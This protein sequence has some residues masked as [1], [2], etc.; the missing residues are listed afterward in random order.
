LTNGGL[1]GPLPPELAGQ[2]QLNLDF[3]R[4]LCVLAGNH[5]RVLS[6]VTIKGVLVKKPWPVIFRRHDGTYQG[7]G[8]GEE[9]AWPAFL[10]V[11]AL[12]SGL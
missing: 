2:E 4:R 9:G 12:P 11:T 6:E 3:H 5:N 7:N 1:K 10:I 8:F